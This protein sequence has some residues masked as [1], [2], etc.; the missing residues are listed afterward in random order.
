MP[1]PTPLPRA[2]PPDPPARTTWTEVAAR[3]PALVLRTPREPARRGSHASF[4]HPHALAISRS[5][6]ARGVIG[7][8][9]PPDLL[10]FGF[11]PLYLRHEEAWR[12]AAVLAEVVATEAWRDPRFQAGGTVP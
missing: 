1:R 6:V 11:T 9:R 12:A 2:A 10:R 3:C 5:L 7:D 8:H 4:A